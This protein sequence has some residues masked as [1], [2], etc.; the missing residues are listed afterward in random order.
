MFNIRQ[1]KYSLFILILSAKLIQ[2]FFFAGFIYDKENNLLA[3]LPDQAIGA[4]D[5]GYFSTV[6]NL[7]EKGEYFYQ[8]VNSNNEKY[9]APRVPGQSLAYLFFRVFLKKTTAI[10]FLILFQTLFYGIA[11]WLLILQLKNTNRLILNKYLLIFLLTIDSYLSFYNNTPYLAESISCSLTLSTLL[12]MLKFIEK[13]EKKFLFFM[14][15]SAGISFFFKVSNLV[16]LFSCVL[17]LLYFGFVKCKKVKEIVTYVGLF[18]CPF[19]FLESAW[20]IRNFS[21]TN[22]ILL[23]QEI[24]GQNAIDIMDNQDDIFYS[25]VNFCKSFGGDYTR[26]NPSSAMA[27]FSTEE[28]LNHMNFERP[29]IEVFPKHIQK[30]VKKIEKL[31]QARQAWWTSLEK[32]A[33]KTERK[34]AT[35][36]AIIIFND[37]KQ[38]IYNNHPFLFHISSRFI[39]S[40]NLLYESSTYYFPYTFAEANIIE[41]LI[42]ILAR[43]IYYLV[44][45]NPFIFF[46]FYILKYRKLNK[47]LID[48]SYLT[49]F[50][51]IFLYSFLF[52]TS[53][54]RYNHAIYLFFM[55]ITVNFIS[56]IMRLPKSFRKNKNNG[57]SNE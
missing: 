22:K 33:T 47:P 36:E 28:Y 26:W 2:L 34:K 29:G 23:T 15:L 43:V 44:M 11:L 12:F 7:L 53:E 5:E 14:G 56:I 17:Y 32:L 38:D 27:W 42:K 31:K 39:Y 18:L 52:R 35:K 10:N 40:F 54:F 4:D 13:E 25:A 48:L 9:I 16:L 19:I 41:K 21:K 20:V 45:I 30:N 24:K 37:L 8:G 55:I 46:P 6:D 50:G 1:R 57:Y 3:T 51:F 49:S